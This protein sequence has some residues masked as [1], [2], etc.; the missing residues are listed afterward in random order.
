MF[1]SCFIEIQF[2]CHMMD[3]YKVYNSMILN[4]FTVAQQAPQLEFIF[5]TPRDPIPQEMIFNL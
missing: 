5:I 3:T 2:M 1:I 4:I